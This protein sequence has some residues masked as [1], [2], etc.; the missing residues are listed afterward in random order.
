MRQ[1]IFGTDEAGY[2][3][4]LGPL[5]V[6]LTVW[7]A[8]ACDI[9][10]LF[11]PLADAGIAIGDSK[12]I[13]QQGSLASLESGVL[14]ALKSISNWPEIA[15]RIVP[16]ANNADGIVRLA[17]TFARILQQHQ[18]RL[19]DMQCRC[20]E[21][22]EF[23]QLLN[24]FNSKGALLSHITLGLV[25]R[26]L[27]KMTNNGLKSSDFGSVMILCDKHGGRNYY[28]DLLTEFF[29]GEYI[30]VVCQGR[31]R[32]IYRLT[33]AD[34]PLEF[35]FLVKGESQLPIALA[36]MYA[37]YQRELA[38][39]EFNAFW[40]SHIPDLQPTAGYPEDAKRFKKAIAEV[41]ERLG[42]A[43][44]SLWRRR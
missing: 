39:I 6:A 34:R 32:S 24:R 18:V 1:I 25:V 13:Y 28:L 3:P 35:Q 26:Q 43:D 19:L 40:R 30:Q 8:P 20:V 4:N 27:K 12:K 15:D 14:V 16:T 31:E 7:E 42:I 37:K 22:E 5:A 29:P 21:P 10:F 17:E 36:S 23:N 38:M 2:G 41:Q 33:F 11:K 9:S 44:A